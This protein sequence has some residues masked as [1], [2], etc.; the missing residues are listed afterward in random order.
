MKWWTPVDA[1]TYRLRQGLEV[2][3]NWGD[4]LWYI[5]RDGKYSDRGFATPHSAMLEAEKEVPK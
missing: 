5:V 2:V 4:D 1:N 3:K